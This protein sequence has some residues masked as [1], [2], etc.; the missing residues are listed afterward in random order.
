MYCNN[1]G[2]QNPDGS[3]FCNSCGA[4]V[5]LSQSLP[6]CDSMPQP[7]D[8][9]TPPPKK[10]GKAPAIIILVV[11]VAILVA[12]IVL[13]VS[14]ISGTDEEETK[15]H[16]RI[17][18]TNGTTETT[19]KPETKKEEPTQKPDSGTSK[20]IAHGTINGNVYR[21]DFADITFTKPD[22][23]DFF[24]D[25]E[26]AKIFGLALD[27]YTDYEKTLIEKATVY[28]MMIMSPESTNI[29]VM[30]E[31]L[32]V[33]NAQAISTEAYCNNLARILQMQN[34]RDYNFGELFDCQLGNISYKAVDVSATEDNLTLYQRCYVR[35]IGK[36]MCVILVTAANTDDITEV[37]SMFSNYI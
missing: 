32:S 31:D 25:E 3:R 16:T 30:F 13:G 9:Q 18:T 36:Y 4:P 17:T 10:T 11:C 2:N 8:F 27:D 12:G 26:L 23:W 6:E 5:Q 19:T 29:C 22:D 14:L 37:E 21:N 1:C 33:S 15:P 34:K 20:K 7:Y 35:K 28:D 24:S